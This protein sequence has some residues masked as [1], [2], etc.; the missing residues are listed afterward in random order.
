MDNMSQGLSEPHEDEMALAILSL[1][2]NMLSW[3]FPRNAKRYNAY[4]DF[5][6]ASDQERERWKADFDLFVRKVSCRYQKRLILKSPNH[7]ARIKLL[8]ELYPDAKFLHIHRHP[9]D[10]FRSMCHMV[11]KVQPVWG[12]QHMPVDEIPEIVIQ[13]YQQLYDAYLDAVPEVPEGQLHEIGYDQLVSSPVETLQETYAKLDL[14]DFQQ[15]ATAL[16]QYLSKQADYQRNRH[17]ELS[18]DDQRRLQ[19]AWGRYFKAWGYQ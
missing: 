11:S 13:T 14:G 4:L 5:R 6:N 15:Y 7:T 16:K 8:L 18:E 19:S 17:A 12:L 9:H 1:K 10:V 2:S 3:A